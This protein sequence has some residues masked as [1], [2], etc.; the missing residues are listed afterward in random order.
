MY[1]HLIDHNWSFSQF[2]IILFI[3]IQSDVFPYLLTRW[4]DGQKTGV[5]NVLQYNHIFAPSHLR[6]FPLSSFYSFS[7]LLFR[8]GGGGL[9]TIFFSP[10]NHQK[11]IFLPK[12]AKWKIYTP[13]R[14][15]IK[16]C[17]LYIHLPPLR[18]RSR[19]WSPSAVQA[20]TYRVYR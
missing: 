13:D 8:G 11:L 10:P 17:I 3:M 18:V 12:L 20:A 15:P 9:L 1:P 19:A 14:K 5:Y 6:E 16:S 4:R 7:S 2:L